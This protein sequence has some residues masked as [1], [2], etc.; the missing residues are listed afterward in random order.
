MLFLELSIYITKKNVHI[1]YNYI[2]SSRNYVSFL[3]SNQYGFRSWFSR[4]FSSWLQNF[5]CPM[6]LKC[7]SWFLKTNGVYLRFLFNVSFTESSRFVRIFFK[8]W[9]D[10][11][12]DSDLIQVIYFCYASQ[13]V[14]FS[15][16]CKAFKVFQSGSCSW[17]VIL[18]VN[19]R[20]IMVCGFL[21]KQ[22]KK[23]AENMKK[24]CGSSLGVAC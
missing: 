21:F 3:I 1:W 23:Y 13:H 14:C 10:S 2:T 11:A 7:M 12:E 4:C 20:E 24:K 15:H 22:L 19:A 5:G 18:C 16:H 9:C 8:S 6:V 17:T